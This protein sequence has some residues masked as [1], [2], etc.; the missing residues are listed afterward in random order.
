[1]STTRQTWET[2]REPNLLRNTASGKYYGRFTIACKQ[3]WINL[4][5]DVGTVAKLR[6]A[7]E[8]SKIERLR[9]TEQN[10]TAGGAGVGDL[11]T[12]YKQ[13]VEDRVDIKPKTKRR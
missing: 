2:T 11:V 5:T 7:D 3:K 4:E 6:L 1:M 10:V 9:Q 8:R 12:L 13:R